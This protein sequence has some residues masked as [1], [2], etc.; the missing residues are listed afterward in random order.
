MQCFCY[1]IR[2]R[3]SIFIHPSLKS[4]ALSS[5]VYVLVTLVITIIDTIFMFSAETQGHLSHHHD[6]NQ[7]HGD[8]S[9]SNPKVYP[10]HLNRE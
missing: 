3:L 2:I 7:V 1:G 8:Y 6:A 5:V 4:S 10:S 9:L